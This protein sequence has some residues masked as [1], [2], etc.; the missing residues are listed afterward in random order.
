MEA[1]F[2]QIPNEISLPA[3]EYTFQNIDMGAIIGTEILKQLFNSFRSRTR[4]PMACYS[5]SIW[6]FLW[7]IFVFKFTS[8]TWRPKRV[9]RIPLWEFYCKIRENIFV[10]I[11]V[12]DDDKKTEF[13]YVANYLSF[14]YYRIHVELL[15]VFYGQCQWKIHNSE[16]S[17]HRL[18]FSSEFDKRKIRRDNKIIAKDIFEIK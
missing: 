16:I 2:W 18:R 9:I 8:N 17:V 14:I 4:F 5:T 3:A 6:L 10:L 15:Y 13:P 1:Y 11:F 7:R 12:H